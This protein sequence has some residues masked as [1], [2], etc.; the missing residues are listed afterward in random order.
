MREKR[1]TFPLAAS[2]ISVKAFTMTTVVFLI[3]VISLGAVL[4]VRLYNSLVRLNNLVSEAWSGIDVQLKKRSDLVP[5]LVKI[6]GAYAAHE[7]GTFEQVTR[8]RELSK[9][10][11]DVESR[12]ETEKQLSQGLQKI[13]ALEERYPDLKAVSAYL[14]LQQELTV[15]EDHLQYA[16]RYY[17][18]TVR[19]LNTQI[20][21]FPG[22]LLAPLLGFSRKKFFQVERVSE[23]E[24]PEVQL[25]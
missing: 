1:R 4:L 16:R 3:A 11:F 23:R 6:V 19:D 17:N 12:A 9:N 2:I 24:R 18:G 22:N 20:E 21:S 14:E 25:H 5:N 10:A 8:A 7:Q 13:I 15:I